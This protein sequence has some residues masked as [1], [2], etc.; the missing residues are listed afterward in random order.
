MSGNLG[1][2]P[3]AWKSWKFTRLQEISEMPSYLGNFPNTQT[4]GEFP[5]IQSTGEFPIFLMEFEGS[6][7]LKYR[8]FLKGLAIWEIS[9]IPRHLGNSPDIQSFE[10]FPKSQKYTTLK[11]GIW[12]ISE[13]PQTPGY[14]GN[15][16]NTQESGGFLKCL[17]IW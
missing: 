6:L 13:I 11:V 15:F 9:Q 16:P 3:N 4:F 17:G 2:S 7:F 1:K 14:L 8:K 10:K 5:N 12:K